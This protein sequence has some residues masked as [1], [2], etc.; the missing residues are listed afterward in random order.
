M[1]WWRA[2]WTLGDLVLVNVLLIQLYI[3]LNFL[4]VIY[5]E[6]SNRWRIWKMLRLL[7]ENREVDDKPDATPLLIAGG[8]SALPM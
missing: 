4:G 3:P 5:R 7:N 8:R 2:A 6:I 1:A